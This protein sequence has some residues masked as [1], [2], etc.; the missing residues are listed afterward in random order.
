MP[1]N[2]KQKVALLL[3]TNEDFRNS[4]KKLL[5]EYW[6]RQGLQL[7][8]RQR[9]VFLNKCATAESITRARRSLREQYPATDEVES[10]RRD[11]ETEY[12]AGYGLFNE[13]LEG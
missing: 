11:Q 4:D 10:K 6:E 13:P 5:L 1:Y 8:A 7:D 12:K 9:Q 3:R 2:L